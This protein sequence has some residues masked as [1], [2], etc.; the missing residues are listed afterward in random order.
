MSSRDA[1]CT[2]YNDSPLTMTLASGSYEGESNP[3]V[4]DGQ[5]NSGPPSSI[6]SKSTGTLNVGK[7]SNASL[8]GPEGWVYY[9]MNNGPETLLVKLTWNHPDDDNPSIYTV[10]PQDSRITGYTSPS[11]PGGHDQTIQYHVN[12]TPTPPNDWDMVLGVSQS[13]INAGLKSRFGHK[14]SFQAPTVAGAPTDNSTWLG[15]DVKKMDMPKVQILSGGGTNVELWLWFTT[16]TL[17]Y[18]S[19]GQRS[20]MALSNVQAVLT[21]NLA[22]AQAVDDAAF[23]LLDPATQAQLDGLKD[24]RFSIWGIYLDLR[25]PNLTTGMR[26]L[27]SAGK[28]LTWTSDQLNTFKQALTT[29]ATTSPPAPLIGLGKPP[30]PTTPALAPTSFEYNTTYYST[31]EDGSTLNV[32]CMTS[33]RARPVPSSRYTMTAPV[34]GAS[35]VDSSTNL[36]TFPS[37]VYL[38]QRAISDGYVEAELLPQLMQALVDSLDSVASDE[39][40]LSSGWTGRGHSSTAATDP[41]MAMI[42]NSY[43]SAL[44]S[45]GYTWVVTAGRDNS[46]LNYGKGSKSVNNNA[47]DDYCYLRTTTTVMLKYVESSA[48][49]VLTGTGTVDQYGHI[50][51][52]PFGPDTDAG[53]LNIAEAEYQQAFTINITITP[54]NKGG[55]L[56]VTT[57]VVAGEFTVVKEDAGFLQSMT[58]FFNNL[59]FGDDTT[60]TDHLAH[61]ITDIATTVANAL[62]STAPRN[63]DVTS[64]VVVLP[65]GANIAYSGINSTGG[66]TRMTVTYYSP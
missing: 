41:F 66:D 42:I 36:T 27:D 61:Q 62:Q 39:S 14:T 53:S 50:Q 3:Y 25:N 7:T 58:N 59:L 51:R 43:A 47:L 64:T 32:F 33:G 40:V 10:A 26:L 37:M 55:G 60:P 18:T 24:S 31:N 65:G 8:S 45:A 44:A 22:S 57:A 63:L 49:V 54:A 46:N 19:N 38:S 1:N 56:V 9:Q 34:G 4:K 23:A 2:I 52:F 15:L 17:Y 11:N 21:V 48:G 6:S 16:A 35:Y 20:S 12:Y 28:P 5:I 13:T 29:W 30:A